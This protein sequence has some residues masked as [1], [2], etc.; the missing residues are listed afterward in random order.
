MLQNLLSVRNLKVVVSS[1]D[2][3]SGRP[4]RLQVS[5]LRVRTPL[6]AAGNYSTKAGYETQLL[7]RG[8]SLLQ[9]IIPDEP[10]PQVWLRAG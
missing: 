4:H 9:L 1:V 2:A 6:Q 8:E 7:A 5:R 3:R 10:T